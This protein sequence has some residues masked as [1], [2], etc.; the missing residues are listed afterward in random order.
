MS[1]LTLIAVISILVFVHELGHFLVA[2]FSNVRVDEFAIGFPP[3]IFS[4]RYKETI[5]AINLI[6]FGGYVKIFGENPDVESIAGP[7]SGRSFVNKKRSI[8]AAIL[9]AGI[10]MNILFAWAL[11]SVTFMM[12]IR[13]SAPSPE[14][15]TSVLVSNVLEGSPAELAGLKPSDIVTGVTDAGGNVSKRVSTDSIQQA[16]ASSKGKAVTVSYERD[17]K[18]QTVSI[19]PS[20]NGDGRPTIGI[21]MT[22]VM[23]SKY[24]FFKSIIEGAK[25]TWSL[26]IQTAIGIVAF[27]QTFFVFSADLSQVSGPVGIAGYLNQAREFGASTLFMFVALISINLAVVNLLPFPALDG[28]RLLFVAIESIIRRPISPKISNTL[29]LIG[30]GLLLLLMAVITV[31]DVGKLFR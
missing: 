29:N 17:G 16:I 25:S 14:L 13:E 30:F 4:F 31:S 2:K 1:F 3:R 18:N 8:Q 7:D 24:G 19:T 28:G 23:E 9:I 10:A 15:A 20:P 12:G 26:T 6:P 21:A 11:L 5:Y 27:L 22:D